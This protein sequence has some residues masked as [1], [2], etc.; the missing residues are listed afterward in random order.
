MQTVPFFVS[1]SDTPKAGVCRLFLRCMEKERTA[2]RKFGSSLYKGWWGSKR[3][4]PV[5]TGTAYATNVPRHIRLT[6]RGSAPAH[7]RA[8]SSSTV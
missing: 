8:F 6:L 1:H 5:K 3:T 2:Q 4:V 7:W